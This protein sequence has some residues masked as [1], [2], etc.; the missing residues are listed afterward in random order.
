MS[1]ALRSEGL[2][3]WVKTAEMVA[4]IEAHPD[5]EIVEFHPENDGLSFKRVRNTTQDDTPSK[6]W[7]WFRNNHLS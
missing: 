1:T 4:A 3:E 7:A 6:V 5:W 2:P